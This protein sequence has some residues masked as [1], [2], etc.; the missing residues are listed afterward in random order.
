[1]RKSIK[2][3]LPNEAA[4]TSCGAGLFGENDMVPLHADGN[5]VKL[6]SPIL[7]SNFPQISGARSQLSNCACV[8]IKQQGWM[9]A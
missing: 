6:Q 2:A 1:M 3:G 9:T 7:A 8:F 4:C 5:R